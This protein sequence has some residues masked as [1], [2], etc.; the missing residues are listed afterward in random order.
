MY[1]AVWVL[2]VCVVGLPRSFS[3][4]GDGLIFADD[5]NTFD[6]STWKHEL[7]M[8]GGGNWE[9]QMYVN[10]RDNSYVRD[11][12]LFIKPTLTT[13][14]LGES[15]VRGAGPQWQDNTVDLWGTGPANECTG[16]QF[17]G[18]F[19]TAT[20]TNPINPIRSARIR[21]ADSFA[22]K[23]GRIEVRAAL[24][25]GNWLW[26]AIWMLPKYEA[27]GPWPASG[28]IDIMESR[29]N[30]PSYTNAK[31]QPLG[32]NTVGSTVHWGPAFGHDAYPLTTSTFVHPHSGNGLSKPCRFSSEFHTFGMVW[33][34][35]NMTFFV[36][37]TVTM[38]VDLSSPTQGTFWERGQRSN[39]WK[40]KSSGNTLNLNENKGYFRNPW[41]G[42]TDHAPFDQE[43]YIVINLA[44]GGISGGL[45]ESAYW[46]DGRGGK[47]WSNGVP[48]GAASAAYQFLA[49]ESEWLPT[50][51]GNATRGESIGESA[52][53]RID[54]I[55]V[56]GM[57]RGSDSSTYSSNV[58]STRFESSNDYVASTPTL[59]KGQTYR[60]VWMRIG[61][62]L[63]IGCVLGLLFS[64]MCQRIRLNCLKNRHIPVGPR[65]GSVAY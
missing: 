50:W 53:L 9:F 10:S 29:G 18:C 62:W 3:E 16:N 26:P 40:D 4:E 54:S 2:T 65:Y 37:D 42:G 36:D 31:G 47:P 41:R 13:D 30:S 34:P 21:T 43:F 32:C 33:S 48:A 12:V 56:W 1:A 61:V 19:R 5:F 15:L 49:G 58:K 6:M 11:G 25:E 38:V 59:A 35:D 20:P 63:G 17:F 57:T 51:R 22:F 27:Y 44:V 14:V 60:L 45:S 23:Y 46:P 55:Q 28:E 7:T 24:P 64:K 39:F 8:G 52:S